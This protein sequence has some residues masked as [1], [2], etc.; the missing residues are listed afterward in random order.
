MA[1]ERHVRIEAVVKDGPKSY[2][3]AMNELGNLNRHMIGG[4]AE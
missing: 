4:L 3:A 2:P 1:L